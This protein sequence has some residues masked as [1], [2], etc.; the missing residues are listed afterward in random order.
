MKVNHSRQIVIGFLI[1]LGMS[2]TIGAEV[3]LTGDGKYLL[4]L[5]DSSVIVTERST[6]KSWQRT[7][8][9]PIEKTEVCPVASFIAFVFKTQQ[10]R[11]R[12]GIYDVTKDTLILGYL[13]E[14]SE[15]TWSPHGNNTF[16]KTRDEVFRVVS[17]KVLQEVLYSIGTV[18]DIVEIV[19]HPAGAIYQESWIGDDYLLFSTG[20]GEA[21]C[22]GVLDIKKRV[23]FYLFCCGLLPK[24]ETNCGIL[25]S[26]EMQRMINKGVSDFLKGKIHRPCS[27]DFWK[28]VK[29]FNES[30]KK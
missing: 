25:G 9:S 8:S 2:N 12:F 1:A 3:R 6:D 17:T 15:T 29:H 24:N 11:K 23:P 10:E 19:G 5:L 21:A 14:R 20:V 26:V 4:A 28:C 30:P 13:N 18:S 22:Y 7:F 16:L 27:F